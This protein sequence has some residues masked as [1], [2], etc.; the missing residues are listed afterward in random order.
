MMVTELAAHN[1]QAQV[2]QIQNFVSQAVQDGRRIDS[3]ERDLMRFLLL[4]GHSLRSSYVAQQEHG[5]LSPEVT[6][7]RRP[8]GFDLKPDCVRRAQIAR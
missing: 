1:D 6:T 3:V 7:P 2:E 4:L 8:H 5:D